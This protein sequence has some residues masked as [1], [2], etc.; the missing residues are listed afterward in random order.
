M[1]T[2]VIL[3]HRVQKSNKYY[4]I[5]VSR[6]VNFQ[7]YKFDLYCTDI[8]QFMKNKMVYSTAHSLRGKY[9]IGDFQSNMVGYHYSCHPM[10]SCVT[11]RWRVV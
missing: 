1:K 8:Q 3:E 7:T 6:A 2:T 11:A 4:N 5:I 10:A 9:T